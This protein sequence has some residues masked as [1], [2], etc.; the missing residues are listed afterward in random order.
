MKASFAFVF[1]LVLILG[2]TIP[3]GVIAAAVPSP[4]S[5]FEKGIEKLKEEVHELLEK[6]VKNLKEDF[7]SKCK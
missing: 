4:A 6:V 7:L 2:I 5:P 1:V 3:S